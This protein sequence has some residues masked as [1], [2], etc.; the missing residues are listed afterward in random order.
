MKKSFSLYAAVLENVLMFAFNRARYLYYLVLR[1]KTI[2]IIVS[3]LG[4][5]NS[6]ISRVHACLK[7]GVRLQFDVNVEEQKENA[8]PMLR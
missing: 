7:T 4:I 2:R 3:S 1:C 8:M 5:V 6:K